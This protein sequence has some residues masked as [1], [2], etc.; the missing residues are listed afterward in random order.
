MRRGYQEDFYFL[1]ERVRDPDSRRRKAEKI[2][3]ALNLN[4]RRPLDNSICLD[5]G[6]SAGLIT[7][8]LAPLFEKTIGLDYDRRALE[9]THRHA[10][11]KVQ[12]LRGDAMDLPF[13]DSAV[14]VIVCSQVYEHVPDAETLFNEMYRVLLPGGVV[15]FSGPNW[16][17]PIEPHYF[18]PFLHWLPER[19]ANLY[20]RF[21]GKGQRYY[22][23]SSHLWGL[24]RMMQDFT[25]RDITREILQ[26]KLA[27]APKALT[28]IV[29]NT[30]N[31]IWSCVLP[32]LP[33]FN[34]ILYKQV[35]AEEDSTT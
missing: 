26:H 14:D 28:S 19:L 20:L 31:L 11:G 3:A 32:F 24:R 15:F 30:P 22:E 17:F 21:A 10:C 29:R 6:C 18:L 1:S 9:A 12:F 27:S 25:V 13:A 5:V 4:G 8:A 7:E 33:N 2:T 35:D 34:W 23:Q 16:L